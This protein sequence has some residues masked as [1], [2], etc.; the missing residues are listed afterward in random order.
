LVG[1]FAAFDVSD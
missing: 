1:K